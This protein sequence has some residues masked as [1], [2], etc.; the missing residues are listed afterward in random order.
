MQ[1]IIIGA[2]LGGLGAAISILLAGHRVKVL[3]SAKSIGEVGAGIQCLPNSTRILQSWDIHGTLTSKAS[4]TETCNILNW[5]GELISSMDFAAAGREHGASFNDFHRADL[6]GVLLSRAIEL[7]ADIQTNSEVVDITFDNDKS[8][9]TVL[10][11]NQ[12]PQKA[13]LVIGADGINSRCREILLGRREPPHRTGDMAYRILLD[14]KDVRK[15]PELVRYLDEKAVNYWYGPG[16]HAG[17][18]YP[19]YRN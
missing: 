17:N 7:G 11:K 18:H 1:V 19:L 2:G 3:E 12:Q 15:D 16:A 6:H 4:Q 10:V 13:D 9:A 5:K 8:I 14:G